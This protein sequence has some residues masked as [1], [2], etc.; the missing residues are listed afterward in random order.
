MCLYDK[1]R[2]VL[3][4]SEDAFNNPDRANKLDFWGILQ[5]HRVM[6]EFV[7][8][9]FTGHT[10][11]HLQMVMFI[12]ETMFFQVELEG[13]SLACAN[14]SA[15]LVTVQNLA[16]SVDAFDSR[17]FFGRYCWSRRGGRSG[18]VKI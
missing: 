15:L 5:A 1:L 14:V 6:A 9:N 7:K 4:V 12:L 17:L 11:F 3:V 10:K 2:D 16:S 18:S 13:V 8:E